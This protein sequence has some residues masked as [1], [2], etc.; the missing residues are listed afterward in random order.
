[1]KERAGIILEAGCLKRQKE[2]MKDWS[3]TGAGIPYAP[4]HMSAKA[5]G[6]ANFI[7]RRYSP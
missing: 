5:N 6:L 7:F 1:M 3:K 2:R 4:E